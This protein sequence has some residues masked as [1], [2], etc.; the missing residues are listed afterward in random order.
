M[1]D[2]KPWRTGNC[3]DAAFERQQREGFWILV[4]GVPLGTGGNAKGMR[5]PHAWLEAGLIVWDPN[6]DIY[7]DA[8][9]YYTLGSIDG[10]QCRRYTKSEAAREA[11]ACGTQGPWDM[12]LRA[13]DENIDKK[14]L[15]NPK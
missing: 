8:E 11:I 9:R 4:H 10:A 15:K 6:A 1:S 12:D 3:F 2:E 7:V 5:Y 14:F 13:L